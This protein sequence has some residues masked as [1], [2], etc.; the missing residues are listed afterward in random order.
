M[1]AEAPKDEEH[2]RTGGSAW[3]AGSLQTFNVDTNTIF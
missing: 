2:Y 1:I 3:A